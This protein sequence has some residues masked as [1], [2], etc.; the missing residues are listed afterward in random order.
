LK[1]L[2]THA[3]RELLARSRVFA[4]PS[5]VT[6]DNLSDGLPVALVEA[7]A[8]GLPLISTPVAGIPEIVID[9]VTGII[10]PQRDAEALA[11]A[12][13]RLLEDPELCRTMGQAARRR[14]E[15]EFGRSLNV[16]RLIECFRPFAAD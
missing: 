5:V 3:L 4:L 1:P 14:A 10:V 6:A 9:G 2:L 13:L 8:M 7:A 11:R 16:R 15:E 12:I